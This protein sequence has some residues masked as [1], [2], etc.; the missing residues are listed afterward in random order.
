MYEAAADPYCYK[1]TS[2]LKNIPGFRD[3]DALDRFEAVATTQ[4]SDE[5]FPPGR[6]DVLH[7]R[8][9]H[10]HLFQDVFRWAGRFRT[11]RIS[12]GGSA[13][14][15]PENISREMSGLFGRLRENRFFAD[16]TKDDF[17]FDLTRF[18]STLNAIHPFREGNGRSQTAFATL[19]ADM[20]G[21]PLSLIGWI[22]KLS[23]RQ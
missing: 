1:G 16:L 12:K 18:L 6:L 17:V 21:H 19:L 8:G 11:V 2:V 22:L 4:R 13:F 20:A 5:P 3:Q 23:S 14:C 9:I 7:Y 10:H 15:Y